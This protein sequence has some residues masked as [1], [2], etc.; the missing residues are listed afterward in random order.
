MLTE[1]SRYAVLAII[2]IL[3]IYYLCYAGESLSL[4]G[5][6]SLFNRQSY[7][8]KLENITYDAGRGTVMSALQ[9]TQPGQ[10]G[11]TGHGDY[12]PANLTRDIRY[13]KYK[14]EMAMLYDNG[15]EYIVQNGV[16][17]YTEDQLRL[18]SLERSRFSKA[19]IDQNNL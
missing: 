6:K 13:P 12:M 14:D 4:R 9:L 3:A 15:N 19:L 7:R 1:Q 10:I 11:P 16:G 8:E 18:N 17:G 2:I 5:V